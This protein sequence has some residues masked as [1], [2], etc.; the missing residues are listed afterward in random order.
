MKNSYSLLDKMWLGYC[1]IRTKLICPK[2]KLFCRPFDLRGRKFVKFGECLS[3]GKC[4]R[5]EVFK[6]DRNTPSLVFGNNVQLNDF[7]H[8]VAMDS[9]VIGNNVLMASHI[10][11]SDNSHGSYHGDDDDSDPQV[12]PIK[13]KYPTN[14]ISIGNNTW[15][16]E[17]V[18]VM[19]GASIGKGCVIGAHSIV[20]G[21]IPDY[22]IAVGN[23]AKIIKKYNFETKRWE[24]T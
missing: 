11:I 10:F 20:R 12:P 7:V 2:A 16:C 9:V 15:I 22:C 4:A 6:N 17:G 19:P 8:I 21:T 5:I 13:R 3:I 1:L 14:P 18:M 24:R 23:P